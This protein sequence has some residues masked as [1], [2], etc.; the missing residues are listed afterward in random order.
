[1]YPT[2]DPELMDGLRKGNTR[3]Y[4]AF[5]EAYAVAVC[6]FVHKMIADKAAAEDITTESFVKTFGRL[7][8]FA[9]TSKMK[10]FLYTT[11]YRK[12]LDFIKGRSI[13]QKVHSQLL[14]DGEPHADDVERQLITTET[15]NAIYRAIDRLQGNTRE[16]I[17]KSIV[18]G[19]S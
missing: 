18:E 1:M 6:D 19:K 5:H 14:Q 7:S 12:A 2:N 8:D 4:Y 17:R 3:S 9:D 11:A 15:L 16:V 13:R 10:G